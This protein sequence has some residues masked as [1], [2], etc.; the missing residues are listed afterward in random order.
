MIAL[1][2]IVDAGLVGGLVLAADLRRV[3]WARI[4]AGLRPTFTAG[5]R[6]FFL[7]VAAVAAVEYATG[8]IGQ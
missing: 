8:V 5:N 4:W 7:L 3:P 2:Y 6:P 1:A